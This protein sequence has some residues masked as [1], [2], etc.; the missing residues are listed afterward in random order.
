MSLVKLFSWPQA[1]PGCRFF[2]FLQPCRGQDHLASNNTVL[3]FKGLA[4]VTTRNLLPGILPAL[5]RGEKLIA[6]LLLGLQLAVW[7][8]GTTWSSWW[9]SEWEIGLGSA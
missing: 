5:I 8:K 2:S 7:I 9:G 4:S 6:F 1:P 3:L